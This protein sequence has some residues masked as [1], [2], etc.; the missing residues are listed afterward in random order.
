MTEEKIR[1]LVVPHT[2]WDRAWYW[3][4]E[5]FR[6]KLI[7]CVRAVIRELK[8]DPDYR[9][10]FDGQVLPLEDYLA[11]C[12]EDAEFFQE[13]VRSGRIAIGPMYCL[14]D[15]YCTGGEALIRNLLIGKKWCTRFGGGYQPVLHMPD[16]FGITPSMPMI[17]AGFD[18][19]AFVFMRGLAGQVPGLTDM[20]TIQGMKPQ[21]PN[22]TRHFIWQTPD[23]SEIRTI[24]LRDGYANAAY[25]G[26]VD[27]VTDQLNVEKYAALL[28][29]AAQKQDDGAGAPLLLMAGVDHQIPH[30][31]QGDSMQLASKKSRY[32]FTYSRLEDAADALQEADATQWTVFQGEFHGSG[33]ASVLGGTLSARI[34]LKQRN[35]AIEQLLVN[36]VEPGAVALRLLG[37]DSGLE[38]AIEHAWKTL[39]VTHPHD[40][41]C[42]CSVDSVHRTNEHIM[43]QAWEAA[44]AV[45]RRMVIGLFKHYG[46][47]LQH[48]TRP[49]FALMNLQGSERRGPARVQFDYEGQRT[50]GDIKLSEAYVIVNEQGDP[51][52]FREVYRGQ[53]AEHPRMTTELEIYA[54]LAPA[55]FT[56]FYIQPLDAWPEWKSAKQ[57]T[58]ENEFVRVTLHKNG[59]FDLE[60][61]ATGL[62]H[63][64]LGLF[65]GQAD[66]GDS[67]DFSDIPDQ[68]EDVFDQLTFKLERRDWP[69]GLVELKASAELSVPASTDSVTRKRSSEFVSIP[70]EVRLVL[71]PSAKQVEVFLHFTN[72]AADHRLRWNLSLNQKVET[73]LAAVKFNLIERPAGGTPEGDKAPRIWPEHPCD[74]FVAAGN[75]CLFSEFPGNYEIVGEETSRLAFTILRSISW[76]TNPVQMAT[77][78]GT[79]AG[80]HT[81]VPE[82]QCIGRTFDMHFAVRPFAPAEKDQLLQEAML[83]RATPLAG[84]TDASVPYPVRHEQPQPEPLYS[85]S[86]P[87]LVSACKPS[88]EGGNLILR[89]FNPTGSAQAAR[90][91]LPNPKAWFAVGLNE[92]PDSSRSIESTGSELTFELPPF[93]FQTLK[94]K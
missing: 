4:T 47:S 36:Q 79:H 6:I 3:P 68:P 39:L 42:G 83:W 81:F 18:M 1:I 22:G 67:Y 72:K 11:V 14:S 32:D 31:G 53:S 93:G 94:M 69:G 48:D 17:A 12:P 89:I 35:A 50:W 28:V 55:T 88:I 59:T 85:I 87:L 65:S 21:L 29:D 52:P 57:E 54:P 77:R 74:E 16:T 13:A 80:P 44:D 75:L 20:I 51:V 64:G 9:F 26:T 7:E 82:G 86:E 91:K 46:G 63:K 27:P 15:V 19:K 45:R 60:E 30:E 76:L 61:K 37:R 71:A 10:T 70:V 58:A 23:G 62:R 2:H 73:S 66:I 43:Q 24:N 5:R 84:Q 34:Y 49:S 25:R 78:P 8:A 40:D 92:E 33:A 90:V 56:R 38:A 41:I